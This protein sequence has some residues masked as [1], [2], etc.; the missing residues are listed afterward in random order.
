MGKNKEN[1]EQT[2]RTPSS[3]IA[4]WLISGLLLGFATHNLFFSKPS[5][6]IE[7]VSSGS[8]AALDMTLFNNV[9]ETVEESYVDTEEVDDQK[10]VYGAIA[11]MVE[12]LGDP[13]S[14][15]LDPEQT[16]QFLPGLEGHIEGI[17]AE[18]TVEEG[19][20]IVVSPMKGSPAERAGILPGDQVLAVNDEPTSEM[21]LFDAIGKI[22][23]LAGT[24]VKL[25]IFREE[26][27]EPLELT[28]IRE[29]IEIPSVALSTET[30]EGK[31]IATLSIY[32][33]SEN[34]YDEFKQEMNTLL[35]ENPDGIILD[36]RR[37]GGG[38]LNVSVQVLG[39]F[40]K[41]EVKAVIVKKS[42]ED[43]KVT[44]TQGKGKL[45]TVPLVVLIDQGSASASEIVAGALQDHGRATLVGQQS[46]G[47][48]SVQELTELQ[49][50]STLR[51]TVAKW[52]TPKGRGIHELGIT[53]DILI[54]MEAAAMST[55]NDTQ[56]QAAV[57]A[58]LDEIE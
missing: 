16:K 13:Y 54:E 26:L 18:L 39:E 34:T 8:E 22:R 30:V 1:E 6:T 29:A 36:L 9:W 50:G 40:F 24:E 4:F 25:S 42:E 41:D 20:L 12:A 5:V 28:L 35:M 52:F 46:F 47:K 19:R 2:S 15:F 31:K 55:E 27:E 53:P 14:A 7:D 37:N 58:L 33:F 48:G 11:G 21:T 43:S 57:Q 44:Y 45:N 3:A 49:D 51:L 17:G 23:G 10:K 32:Q 56:H 38:Y